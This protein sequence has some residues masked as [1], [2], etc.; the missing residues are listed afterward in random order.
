MSLQPDL[1]PSPVPP[2]QLGALLLELY[3]LAIGSDGPLAGNRLLAWLGG[4]IDFDAAWF[5][6]S[7]IEDGLVTP[8]HSLTSGLV[9]D[10]VADWR[11]VRRVDPVAA[12]AVRQPG[13]GIAMTVQELP[14][15]SSIRA[16]GEEHRL[17]GVLGI[18]VRKP[19]S[20]WCA[21]LSLY[22]RRPAAYGTRERALL[23]LLMPHLIFVMDLQPPREAALAPLTPREAEV[24]RLFGQ[25]L[26]YKAVARTLDSSPATVR[27]HL[28][29]AYAKLGINS[30]VQMARMVSG[31]VVE[32]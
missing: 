1:S 24:A 8:Q 14:Q 10:F 30:K 5:G 18:L 3:P 19:D 4:H 29:Q 28:R 25:G 22:R 7:T 11:R 2:E 16:F 20:P 15:R 23:Q 21:H 32:A 27:H 26:S 6:R 9:S 13:Q 31:V 12:A 17:A